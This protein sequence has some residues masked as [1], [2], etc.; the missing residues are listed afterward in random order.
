MTMLVS[1]PR[2]TSS[3]SGTF[4]AKACVPADAP[5]NRRR[6]ADC[7]VLSANSLL[8]G[9]IEQLAAAHEL[10]GNELPVAQM[11]L[12]GRSPEAMAK[13]LG[14]TESAAQWH[15][16]R[17]LAK[18]G[19]ESRRELM[20]AALRLAAA[21][22]RAE[23]A[24]ARSNQRRAGHRRGRALRVVVGGWRPESSSKSA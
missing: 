23:R 22:G 10:H 24:A 14:I 9:L 12:F 4:I 18:V 16:R 1:T 2:A 7:Q 3:I 20:D 21:K 13:R 19:V 5:A 17:V 15:A 8:R 6:S 11:L